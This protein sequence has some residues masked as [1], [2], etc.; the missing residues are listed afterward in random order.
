MAGGKIDILIEP[1]MK[2]FDSKLEAGLGGAIGVAGKVAAGIGA[3]IGIAGIGQEIISVG[4]EFQ[5]QMNTMAAV[6]QATA[7]QLDAVRAR[8][9]ELGSDVSLTATSASD[10][11]A[12]MTELAKGGFSV[13]QSMEAAKGTL[14]LA[15]AAQ[16]DA[17]TAATIQSQALQ[18]FSLDA[19]HASRV[20]DI[21]AGAANASSAE[22]TDVAMALQ[23]AGTVA[24][25][26][27]ISI[28]DTSTAI[29]MFAN[30][31]I[32]G[33]DAGTLLK[34][35]L[36]ALTD[37]GKPAQEAIQK[38][39]LDIYDSQGKFVGLA[40]LMDQLNTAAGRMTE[41]QYQAA[42]ATLFGSDAMRMASIAAEKGAADFDKLKE[43]VTREGQ[44][45]EVAA[46]QTQ[47]LPGALERLNNAKEDVLL[48]IFDA[49]QG[50]L[51]TA[52][53]AGTAALEKIGPAAESSIRVASDAV[54]GFVSLIS[55]ALT[56]LG[57]IADQ[58]TG[59]LVGMVGA[60][61]LS[62]WAQLPER[63]DAGSG[64]LQRFRESLEVQQNLA[65]RAG[66]EIGD[67]GAKVAS[68]EARVP[69]FGQMAEAFRQGSDKMLTLG[70]ES[71]NASQELTGFAR[72]SGT[73]KGAVQT[74]GGVLG[75]SLNAGLA[76]ARTGVGGL[77]DALGGPWVVGLMAAGAVVGAFV[78]ANQAAAEAQHKMA[79]AAR[80]ASDAQ[81]DLMASV[82]G[83]TGALTAQ[84]T[85]AAAKVADA[86]LT[87][88]TA[89]GEA[90]DQFVA[91]IPDHYDY[92]EKNA[93]ERAEIREEVSQTKDAYKELKSTLEELGFTMSDLSG[94]VA[95]GG[96]NFDRLMG[97]LRE[98]GD[99]GNLAADKLQAA[100]DEI[101]RIVEAARRVDPAAAQAAAGIDILA[102]AASSADDKL[103][104]LESVMEA[105]G[106]APVAAQEA[107]MDAAEAVNEIVASAESANR[108]VEELGENL[109]DLAS[110]SLDPT[111]A[112][113]RDLHDKLSSLRQE[114][115]KVAVAGGNTHEA[116]SFME[117]SF[118]AL[119]EEFGLTEAQVRALAD[120]YGVLPREINTA[121]NVSSEGV[122]AE[123]ATVFTQLR[124][125]EAGTTIEVEAVGDE[126][127]KMLDTIG[128]KAVP[129]EDG[130]N[131][132]LTATTDDALNNL[133]ELSQ[134]MADIGDKPVDVQVLLD[135]SQLNTEV[136]SA[137]ALI[138]ELAISNP[139]PQAQLIIDE[140]LASGEIAK[141]DIAYLSTL[142]ALPQ[143]D[144]EKALLDAG[145]R[146]ANG[147][148]MELNQITAKP[149][150]D[151]DDAQAH[152]KING[153]KSA[154]QAL[155]NFATFSVN[156]GSTIASAATGNTPRRAA[157]GRLPTV[158][159]GTDRVDGILGVNARGVPLAWV[160]A[161][162]WVVNR[163]A[164]DQ[165]NNTL[166]AINRGDGAAAMEA[167]YNELP[168]HESGGRVQRV[169]DDLA[170]L[171]GTPYI[172]G[173]F[174]LA[175]V[176]CSGAVSAAVNSW[177][178]LPVFH[179]R[180][181]TV[182][183]GG[184]LAAKGAEPGRGGLDDLVIGWWD[185]GGGANGHTALR[186][187]DGTH[188]ESGGNTGGGLTIGRTA[189]PMDGRGFTNWAHFPA[190][191]A[192][193]SMPELVGTDPSFSSGTNVN[194][195]EAAE[196]HKLAL[197]YLGAKVYD[198]GGILPHRGVA[199]NVSGKPERIL[200]PGLTRS[201]DKL[202]EVMPEAARLFAQAAKDLYKP[203]RAGSRELAVIGGG[204]LS[205]SQVVIDAEQ[206]LIDT[207]KSIADEA[208]EIAQAEKELE[209]ARKDLSKAE[210]D[211]ADKI[212]DAQNRLEKARSKKNAS[213]SEIADAE[214]NL[215]KVR[216]DAPDKATA[217]AEKIAKQEEKLAEAREKAS[218]A[219]KRLEAAERTVTAAYYQALADLIEGVSGHV[220]S[221]VNRF[222][223]FFNVLA[224]S[225]EMVEKERQAIGELRQA[226]I[227]NNLA[228]RKSIF[229]LQ[230]AEWDLH[231][232]RAQG[233]MSVAQAERD[234][235]EARKAQ[236]LLESTSIEA[237]G[238]AFDRFRTT[239]V[240]AIGQVAD[241]VINNSKAVRA[242][243]WAVSAARAQA[244]ADLHDATVKQALAQFD[245]AEATLVQANAAEMLRIKTAALT[246]YAAQLYGLTPNAAQGASTGFSGIGKVIGGL[247]KIAAGIAAGAAGFAAGG[248]LGAI[249]GASIA[250]GGLG[251]LVRGGF[252]AF[253]NKDSMKDAWKGMGTGQ[254]IGVVL[255]SLGGGALAIG[256]AAL[257]PEYGPDAAIG[258][259]KLAD[260]WIDA[261]LG[262]MA[263]GVESKIAA[264]TRQTEDKTN[265]LTLAT[266]AQ[267]LQIEAQRLQIELAGH[268]KAQ[269]LQAQVEY[270]NLQKQLAEA[271]TKAEMEALT[272]AARV[273]AARRDA[274]LVLAT[275]QEQASAE[276]LTQLKALVD[277]ARQGATNNGV[278][279]IDITINIPDG[280]DRF[281][282]EDVARIAADTVKAATGVEYVNARI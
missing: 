264:I 116:Y 128:I 268:A 249:P 240:F 3:A 232:T 171:D 40:S 274:M 117:G 154:L 87:S 57:D 28:D 15:A 215:Q 142:T 260:L 56:T 158:G 55:P 19:S 132:E 196:L 126:A 9:R 44:A 60:L 198:T 138:D 73:A 98:S 90:L 277:A 175:G 81:N 151:V 64:A 276:Q 190:D 30:A 10:A 225:A 124:P 131:M 72:A 168:A 192:D 262:G 273:A 54:S 96:S 122:S 224:K 21:L 208:K 50:D 214:R 35:A 227:R 65:A 49:L 155:K 103:S 109:G 216:E 74:F 242:A 202:A 18:A 27:G 219:A 118:A 33:S 121:I 199:V 162:E 228:L 66:I 134:K 93:K 59:P 195:G 188:I 247:G 20:S 88:F 7:E 180:M 257:A 83:T 236:A 166:A 43:S 147:S 197:K 106:L 246:Q 99:A 107:M 275:R 179:S 97:S 51:V 176:D 178:G 31:G 174:S 76:A 157:G 102:N 136:N 108:P 209:K 148:L 48:G 86:Y 212:V 45:A 245:V 71:R 159:P 70:A 160:D 42:T 222:G 213:A 25:A 233:A 105:M 234:L 183:E 135:N 251:D 38:L 210:R 280:V 41:E 165:Y 281:T 100:R 254:K 145:L 259:S 22:M 130:I 32:T 279:T 203:L 172:M 111:N 187:P 120:A 82:A 181:S 229:D 37:Q 243:E 23:Q 16:V 193:L 282:R 267:K 152:N 238:G 270:A 53:N 84:A 271:N 63:V 29:A 170:P 250:L 13:S 265:Q 52:A 150:V 119:A 211:N 241:S 205:K 258:G 252:D 144:L 85:E 94:I 91:K 79:E 123:L 177:V 133:S 204:F 184:W 5:S 92:Y 231:T 46:A 127:L 26:F 207:R 153:I 139:S 6:S 272:E 137:K 75:G 226:Q 80:V 146:D 47:G 220:A 95:N 114:L 61:A 11:A 167:L 140:F 8:A 2:G 266:D 62:K 248:P 17:S 230:V 253:N 217:A 269:A 237:L 244:A 164:S 221:A 185:R 89:S 191:S 278:R 173:G 12:A 110:G 261:T 101:D 189:G 36:L 149:K 34:T 206:G 67:F 200:S 186:L 218:N 113:A 14:Q 223:E 77:V 24:N 4:T 68:L 263:H 169:K 194:W 256:G 235:E 104:A 58:A 255:G 115:E 1:D 112:S 125:L 78:N 201:F 39:G 182:T 69:V 161:G 163:K 239:G 143:A 141:G 129:L 156:V